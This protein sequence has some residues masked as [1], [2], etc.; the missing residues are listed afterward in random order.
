MKETMRLYV[1][2]ELK[3]IYNDE[4]HLLTVATLPTAPTAP[5]I[6]TT[7]TL[8]TGANHINLWSAF[9]DKHLINFEFFRMQ[10]L[11]FFHFSMIFFDVLI[12]LE[13]FIPTKYNW[14]TTVLKMT[15][16]VLYDARKWCFLLFLNMARNWRQVSTGLFLQ[17]VCMSFFYIQFNA[18]AQCERTKSNMSQDRIQLTM[19]QL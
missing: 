13:L 5:I 16:Q 3:P 15:W 6:P 4:S 11:N 9:Q 19:S 12:S 17:I 1:F 14:K 7:A 18:I 8:P 2:Q 10:I